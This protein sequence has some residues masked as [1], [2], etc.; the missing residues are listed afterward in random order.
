[1]V[2]FGLSL[3][4]IAVA[5]ERQEERMREHIKQMDPWNWGHTTVHKVHILPGK[6]L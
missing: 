1:M 4:I 3:F 5:V 2:C 6:I